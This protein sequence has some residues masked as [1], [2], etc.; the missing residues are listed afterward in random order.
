MDVEGL[1]FKIGADLTEFSS[2][3]NEAMGE[4][5][6]MSGK[7][8]GIGAGLTAGITAPLMAIGGAAFAAAASLDG[9]FDGIRTKT[10]QT[11]ENL[12]Q[13][14]ES[15]RTVFANVPDAAETVSQAIGE[16]NAR[17]GQ[18]GPGL[19]QLAKQTLDLARVTGDQ[20]GPM[21]ASTTRLFGDWSVEVSKQA[22]AMDTLYKVSQMTGVGVTQ[23][24]EKMVY[25]GA[26]LRQLGFDMDTAATM[27]GKFEKE[28]V[29]TEIVLGAMK[30]A[31][32]KFGAA[33]KEPVAAFKELVEGIKNSDVAT[34][35]LMAK[36]ATNVKV[37]ADFAA[38]VREGRLDLDEMTKTMQASKETIAASVA[39]TQDFAEAWSV[40]KNK[41]MLA[42]EPLGGILFNALN[43]LTG[44]MEPLLGVVIA[45]GKAFGELSPTTQ[46]V[47]VAIAALAAAAGPILVA[48]GAMAASI[49]AISAAIGI[50]M[51]PAFLAGALIAIK[52]VAIA[53]AAAAAAFLAWKIGEWLY[54]FGP[55]KTVIDAI[56]NAISS[57]LGWI[58][59]LPGV[60]S[61]VSAMS[62]AWDSVKGAVSSA[63]A[64]I[65][66]ATKSM[67]STT[68]VLGAVGNAAKGAGVHIAGVGGH[69][70][71]MS[72]QAAAAA[73]Q[74]QQHLDSTWKSLQG[75][76]LDLPKTFEQASKAIASGF[77]IDGA[78]KK[79]VD[80]M[81]K[82]QL[83]FGTKM[84]AAAQQMHNALNY[85]LLTLKSFQQ[86]AEQIKLEVAFQ[87]ATD[88]VTAY[89][90]S[91]TRIM[92]EQAAVTKEVMDLSMSAASKAIADVQA[93]DGAFKS[94]GVTW[95]GELASK[96]AKAADAFELIV[97][98]Q[99]RGEVSAVDAARAQAKYL[100]EQITLAKATEKSY[101]ELETKLK[102]VNAELVLLGAETDKAA[103]K[104]TAAAKVIKQGASEM[105]KSWQE[106]GKQ[107]STVFTDFGKDIANSIIHSK[108][109]G[110][111]FTKAASAI[112]E[113]FMRL[114]V[115]GAI[116]QM[117]QGL[118]G[119]SNMLGGIGK[120]LS[121][122]LGGFGFGG[123]GGG[124][125]TSGPGGGGGAG[126]LG[127]L[128]SLGGNI[129][130]VTGITTAITGVL[131]YV[132]GRHME[133]DIAAVEVTTRGMLNQLTS[134][135]QT[136]NKYLPLLEN[137]VQLIRLEGIEQ[138]IMNLSTGGGMG[139][140]VDSLQQAFTGLNV[141]LQQGFTALI[142]RLDLLTETVR[143]NLRGLID[144]TATTYGLLLKPG[145]TPQYNLTTQ[146]GQQQGQGGQQGQQRPLTVNVQTQSSDPYRQGVQIGQGVLATTGLRF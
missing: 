36:Q 90:S 130:L 117:M 9:A 143:L 92:K 43:T 111:A 107:V 126:G 133:K 15:F 21:I 76:L 75:F 118:D 91:A 142:S 52:A 86:Q 85:T 35:N 54:Q 101:V 63:T 105:E 132:Q 23:L 62:G 41:L 47:V 82:L 10:G 61:V 141:T 56:G 58:S 73:K 60:S 89:G 24:A 20:L 26:P 127:G 64:K 1:F 146:S 4:V 94:L 81:Q 102:G 139:A 123:G 95:S 11:G 5:G 39:D 50:L 28:G 137:N 74:L 109:L 17:T 110:E 144:I 136:M 34:G 68:P 32:G 44:L 14:K 125:G 25:A 29:N 78:I 8:A 22:P 140:L 3:M 48:F 119:V 27:I 108:N 98:A 97:Q 116:K 79:T 145:S 135:Q 121:G 72:K 55:V 71:S 66:D 40:F 19:E 138:G 120:Q 46:A 53:A 49:S 115:E 103:T 106:F 96:A 12:D 7:L 88:A 16:L 113:A 30:T 93:L 104:H 124:G 77:D 42:L 83:E 134:M 13:L 33:G 99:K 45:A 114:V 51:G 59:K 38:A 6:G 100:A 69:M 87:K 122:L 65:G 2:K 112:K 57:M 67:S 37:F 84:P 128:G 129:N 70:E 131:S 80:E 31:L 18:M